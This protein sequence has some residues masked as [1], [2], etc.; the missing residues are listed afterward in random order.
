MKI[1]A[2]ETIYLEEFPNVI[3]CRVHTDEGLIGLGET[4]YGAEA[5]T[6][7]IHQALAPQLIGRDPSEIDSISR[8]ILNPICGFKSTGAE[9]RGGSAIDIALWDLAGKALGVPVHRLLG[10][11]SR[12]RVRAYNT[13][14]GYQY[15]R[16]VQATTVK[17]WSKVPT[18]VGPYEDLEGFLNHADEVAE[19]LLEMGIT[20]MKIWPFDQF[21]EQ[22]NGAYMSAEDMK[23]A[24]EP[25]E[26]IRRA[27]GDRMDI[28]VELHSMWNLPMAKRIAEALRPYNPFWLEDPIKMSNIDALAEYAR[29]AGAW[30]TASEN[31]A[32]RWSFR[33]MFEKRATDVAMLDIGW[34][35]GLTEAKKIATMAEAYEL[36]IAPHDCTGPV[37]LTTAV[38]LAVNAPNALVQEMVRAFYY[39]WYGEL[40][41]GMPVLENGYFLAPEGPGLGI[42]LVPDVLKREDAVIRITR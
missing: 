18:G 33:D 6:G 25:F 8:M 42:D 15:V 19:S 41:T 21:A 27:V 17:S 1:T 4:Y 37:L 9:I 30:V 23:K 13:C 38:H 14:A 29:T 28:H 22:H 7:Y 31:L 12:D 5:V 2:F 3:W 40:T 24:L 39:G 32:T 34:C 16:K 36:P 20:G 11:K 35:G 10:G 26:K